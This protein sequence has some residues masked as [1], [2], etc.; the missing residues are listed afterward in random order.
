[1]KFFTRDQLNELMQIRQFPCVSLYLPVEKIT[2]DTIQG[3]KVLRKMLKSAEESLKEKGV[4]T[5]D[6]ENLL[7]PAYAL[8][9]NALFW[10]NQNLGLALFLDKDGMT[11]HRL[12]IRFA[13]SLLVADR[14]L[15]RPL[16]SM[17]GQDGRYAVLAL[18]LNDAHLY[19]CTR[20]SMMEIV[21]TP[22]PTSLS[23]VMKTYDT[24]SILSHSSG[25]AGGR[26]GT[27]ASTTGGGGG[28]IMGGSYDPKDDEKFRIQ[29]YF[30]RIDQNLKKSLADEKTP[31]VLACVEYLAPM[32]RDVAKDPRIQDAFIAGGVDALKRDDILMQGWK[33]VRPIFE[34]DKNKAVDNLQNALGTA[35]VLQ[36]IRK[37]LMAAKNGQVDTLF[38]QQG[39]S[40]LGEV[41]RRASPQAAADEPVSVDEEELFDFAATRVMATGGKVF[42]LQPAEMP[43]P[44]D[45]LALL[46]YQ[47]T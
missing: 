24:E 42:V 28:F 21:M 7:K 37:I 40:L 39:K 30:R 6:I 1:M 15:V 47:T 10:E 17:L 32:F 43:F 29:E 26:A 12:P 22:N 41:E 45:C 34:K 35:R 23:D 36:D 33:I 27:G 31:I 2:N 11:E 9:D 14:F 18:S 13:E 38:L 3:S 20:F 44:A 46:R 5:P 25:S 8:I 19:S 4:R 16:L